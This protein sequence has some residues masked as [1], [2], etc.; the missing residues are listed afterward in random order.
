M[1]SPTVLHTWLPHGGL[2]FTSG[3]QR[4]APESRSRS[5][6]SIQTR[7]PISSVEALQ[8][9]NS[10]TVSHFWLSSG[11]PAVHFGGPKIRA[12]TALSLVAVR[13]NGRLNSAC[14]LHADGGF[15]DSV[16]LL[17]P[18]WESAIEFGGAKFHARIALSLGA[19]RQNRGVN[20]AC[21]YATNVNSSTISHF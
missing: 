9:L 12:R 18:Q 13:P 3:D 1:N 10:S 17:A 21:N 20:S 19:V 7:V 11:G 2:Q 15:V 14:N 4:F 6:L 5:E 8:A 16:T